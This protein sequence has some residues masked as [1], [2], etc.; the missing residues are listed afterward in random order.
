MMMSST[1]RT[2]RPSALSRP[3]NNP[4][5][6]WQ[7]SS[8]I[9]SAASAWPSRNPAKSGAGPFSAAMAARSALKA[10]RRDWTGT[11]SVSATVSLV[12]ARR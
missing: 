2:S 6:S 4:R 1:S 9:R 11:N 10:A 3:R 12:R 7:R 5:L 8:K